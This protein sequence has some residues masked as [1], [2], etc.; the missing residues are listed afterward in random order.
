[1]HT[2]SF[3]VAVVVVGLG[4]QAV[5][6]IINVPGDQ[7]TIQAGVDAAVDGDEVV[8]ADG[9]YTGAG[10]RTINTGTKLITVRSAGGPGACV[11][12]C[13]AQDYAFVVSGGARVEGFTVRNGQGTFGGA[14]FIDGDATVVDC[15]F[16]QCTADGGGAL[17]VLGSS[18]TIIGCTFVGNRAQV[19]D[20]GALYNLY[21]SPVLVDCLMVDNSAA[22]L[23]GAIFSDL[24]FLSLVN[25]TLSGNAAFGGGAICNY[26]GVEMGL[27]NCIV[28]NNHA[29]TGEGFSVQILSTSSTENID[30]TCVQDIGGAVQGQGNID[31]DPLFVDPAN[32][33]YHLQANSPLID[34]GHNWA[35]AGIADTDLDGNPR[36]ADDPATVD[37]GCGVPIIV[38]M[39]AY[40]FQGSPATVKLGDIDGD[41]VVAVP[42][43]LTLL[44]AWGPA[45]GCQLADF[46]LDG[47]VGVPDLL[48]LLANWTA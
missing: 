4:G 25:C 37:T 17:F 36:F 11:I 29:D 32:G 33:D 20:G 8:V 35:I 30:Y 3:C 46:D 38:D 7:P 26:A 15:V 41:G 23:G 18:P 9:V 13:E 6:G 31:A 40:E 34:A 16:E 12:D 27:S 21:G 2:L 47:L 24:A 39:G 1:M 5:A 43:L 28:W 42:D 44:A 10:N 48:V 19:N 45:S 22:Q 14:M